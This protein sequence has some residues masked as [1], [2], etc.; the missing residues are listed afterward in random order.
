MPAYLIRHKG[1][2]R[3]DALIEDPDLSLSF[4]GDW[5]V[6]SDGDGPSFAI[7]AEQ[8]ASIQRIDPDD[9]GQETTDGPAPEG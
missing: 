5:A 4:S 9:T 6:F 3:G 8:A 7:P 1:G 2:Q